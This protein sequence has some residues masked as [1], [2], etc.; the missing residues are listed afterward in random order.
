MRAS[1]DGGICLPF[2]ENSLLETSHETVTSLALVVLATD[3]YREGLAYEK[4]H[5]P[6]LSKGW[7]AEVP[8]R[9]Q[10]T[11]DYFSGEE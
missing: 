1:D 6:D 10:S 11:R 4:T 2:Y 5:P 8:I 7:A 9:I 3:H